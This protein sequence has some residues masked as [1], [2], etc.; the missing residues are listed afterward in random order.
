MAGESIPPNANHLLKFNYEGS[1]SNLTH[2]AASGQ[3]ISVPP[4]Q[5]AKTCWTRNVPETLKKEVLN[6]VWSMYG[7]GAPGLQPVEFR[8]CW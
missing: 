4:D 7:K 3:M 5:A 8:M 2:H 6:V 1:F